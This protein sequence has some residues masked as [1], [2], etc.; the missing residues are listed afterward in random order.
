MQSQLFLDRVNDAI[1]YKMIKSLS[2][3]VTSACV[4]YELNHE[5]IEISEKII[6]D[7]ISEINKFDEI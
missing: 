3:K 4:W 5:T 1:G 6:D 7:I 2:P